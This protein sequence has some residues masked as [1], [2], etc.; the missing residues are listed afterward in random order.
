MGGQCLKGIFLSVHEQTI[1]FKVYAF[2]VSEG[3]LKLERDKQM[4]NS[5][6]FSATYKTCMQAE[7][8]DKVYSKRVCFLY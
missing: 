8:M 7:R 6:L 2:N 1:V 5:I 4:N 3:N